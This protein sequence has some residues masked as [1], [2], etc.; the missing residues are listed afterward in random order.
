V[1]QPVADP[2]AVTAERLDGELSRFVGR[3]MQQPPAF[4]A[5]KVAGQRSYR[6]A[7][8][9]EPVR[10]AAREVEVF[11][12]QVIAFQPGPKAVATVHVVCG[13]GTYLRALARDLGSGLGVGGYLGKLVRSAYG[14]LLIEDA[15]SLDQLADAAAVEAR[16]LPPEVILP[17]M[18][19]VRL[20]LEQTAQ[21]RQG[22]SVRVLPEPAPGPVRAHD[23]S[24]RLIALGH[25]DPLR[26]TFVPEK[27]L[28]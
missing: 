5:V 7:R 3:I 1:P 28:G 21:V 14:P 13:S 8:Q 25:T 6:R 4:S 19:N 16:L 10:P 26:R 18:Q 15:V 27:V 24:G 23:S 9:G 11:S 20:T 17:D 12:A 22:R 2:S